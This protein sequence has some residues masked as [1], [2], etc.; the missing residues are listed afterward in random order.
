MFCTVN[1]V[2]TVNTDFFSDIVMDLRSFCNMCTGDILYADGDDN[3]MVNFY[4]GCYNSCASSLNRIG[5][6]IVK[7]SFVL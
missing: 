6:D 3:D 1:I 5:N 4:R 2:P 7:L